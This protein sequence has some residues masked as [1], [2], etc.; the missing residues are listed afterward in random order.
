MMLWY[1]IAGFVLIMTAS[2][3]RRTDRFEDFCI[4]FFLVLFLLFQL[5]PTMIESS[6]CPYTWDARLQAADLWLGLDGFAW[7]KIW[8]TTK[9][10][11]DFTAQAYWGLP[12]AFAVTWSLERSRTMATSMFLAGALTFPLYL[13][14]P[15][16]GPAYAFRGWPL[17]FASG[18]RDLIAVAATHPRNCFPSMHLAWALLLPM[19]ANNRVWRAILL[20]N[21]VLIGLATIGGGEHY[22]VDLF[23]AVPFAFGVQRLSERLLT[24]TRTSK[25]GPYLRALVGLDAN[26]VGK[27]HK[28]AV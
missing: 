19:N 20:L 15:A 14:V 16:A 26:Q 23:A 6:L 2:F 1:A 12:L 11:R 3:A 17:I 18:G 24:L 28:A 10:L 21:A 4:G 5:V 27:G 22:F 8:L 13:L 7:A 25:E 9:W